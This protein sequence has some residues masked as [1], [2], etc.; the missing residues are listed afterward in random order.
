MVIAQGEANGRLFTTK[1]KVQKCVFSVLWH[2]RLYHMGEQRLQV[3][4][5][6]TQVLLANEGL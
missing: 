4:A 5:R 6:K 1:V 3:L 2:N